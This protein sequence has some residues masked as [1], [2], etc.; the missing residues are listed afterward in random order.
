MSK[1]K[2]GRK[3]KPESKK[4]NQIVSL[5][6]TDAEMAAVKA[7]ATDRPLGAFLRVNVLTALGVR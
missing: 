4:R 6:F 7:L 3:A 1:S 2:A 5:Y